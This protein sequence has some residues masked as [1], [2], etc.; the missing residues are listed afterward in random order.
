MLCALT[1]ARYLKVGARYRGSPVRDCSISFDPVSVRMKTPSS[2][3]TVVSPS[4]FAALLGC[5]SIG[6][7]HWL[8]GTRDG[9]KAV[10]AAA[11]KVGARWKIDLAKLPSDLLVHLYEHQFPAAMLLR[12]DGSDPF[13]PGQ[14]FASMEEAVQAGACPTGAMLPTPSGALAPICFDT[15]Q[16]ERLLSDLV[17]V[18][19]GSAGDLTP[20]RDLPPEQQGR[21]LFKP[22]TR[23][24]S[25]AV[26]PGA[27][28]DVLN[29]ARVELHIRQQNHDLDHPAARR[30]H[31]LLVEALGRMGAL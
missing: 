23:W 20:C 3:S 11:R 2:T 5:S 25:K 1:E 13:E 14:T 24:A 28:L 10:R 6:V 22:L 21:A 19:A 7:R 30:A 9:G 27:V 4:G 26:G 31:A 16:T 12:A 29:S 18:E 15:D 8:N 17:L